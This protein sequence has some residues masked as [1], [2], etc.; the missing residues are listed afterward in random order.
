MITK[1]ITTDG[2]FKTLKSDWERLQ[3]QDPDITYYSTFEYNKIWWDVYK[4]DKDKSLFIICAYFNNK[5]AGIAPFII[6]KIPGI[7]F[8]Y[9]TLKFMGCGDYL[10][11][12]I[13]RKDNK[14]FT[15]IKSIIDEI[16]NNNYK[17]ERIQLTG[18]KGNSILAAY[19]LRHNELN[20]DFKVLVECP[21]INKNDYINYGDY[22]KSCICP[23]VN[24][25]KNRLGSKFKYKFKALRNENNQLLDKLSEIHIEE[26][27]FVN[28]VKN[29]KTRKSLFNNKRK[30]D[31]VNRIYNRNDNI[32]I[33]IL[34][35]EDKNIIIYTICYLYKRTLYSW[36]TAFN[37]K[38]KK[39]CVGK[40]MNYE[41]NK[42]LFGNDIADVYD[43]GAGRYP[44]KFEWTKNFNTVYQLSLWNTKTLK[45]RA[46]KF[47]YK[48]KEIITCIICSQ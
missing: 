11:F 41:I 42:F 10:N 40:V 45:G 9:N 6:E 4:N 43:F 36:N 14:E 18:I 39:Y 8:S 46:L 26:Q 31:F 32:V 37:V 5:A 33:F 15:I 24:M 38:Y 48:I 23:N 47:L 30:T 2:D 3:E 25:Y 19:I 16:N 34:E 44:W 27:D 17:F 28:E 20:N 7:A 29:I 13:E 21:V 35:S 22:K 12:L 1:L